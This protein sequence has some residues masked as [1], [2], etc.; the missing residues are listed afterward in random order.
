MRIRSLIID[1]DAVF[2]N[3]LKMVFNDLPSVQIEV[4]DNIHDA[5]L[6]IQ[7]MHPNILF[8]SCDSKEIHCQQVFSVMQRLKLRAVVIPIIE[9]PTAD[10]LKLLLNQKS[11]VDILNK[12][13]EAKR[14][15]ASI[16]KAIDRIFGSMDNSTHYRGF[17]GF[18]GVTP[19]LRERKTL[20][21]ARM[22]II[23]NR[24]IRLAIDYWRKNPHSQLIALILNLNFRFSSKEED[25]IDFWEGFDFKPWEIALFEAQNHYLEYWQDPI[26]SGLLN[27]FMP[28]LMRKEMDDLEILDATEQAEIL[29]RISKKAQRGEI[30]KT[31]RSLGIPFHTQSTFVRKPAFA[32][33]VNI[34]EKKMEQVEEAHP[35]LTRPPDET[36]YEDW[37]P[38]KAGAMAQDANRMAFHQKQ[39]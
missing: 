24:S 37:K 20:Q 29:L 39:R 32:E 25:I 9:H 5:T 38:D 30:D 16:Q 36:G 8:I 35:H 19:T 2:R 23:H 33:F 31:F 7:S 21:T 14:I 17:V 27:G 1:Q 11:V 4:A 12:H 26:S 18:I 6:L 15:R 10:M 22:G 34:L 28:V 3:K 13:A